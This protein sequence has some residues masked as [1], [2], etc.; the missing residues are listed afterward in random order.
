M[1]CRDS[2]ID[3]QSPQVGTSRRVLYVR[4]E[5]PGTVSRTPMALIQ[6]MGHSSLSA[7]LRKTAPVK[8]PKE[9]RVAT[10]SS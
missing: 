3:M 5:A 4:S 8:A 7:A 1:P 10:R 9:M 2:I 6:K